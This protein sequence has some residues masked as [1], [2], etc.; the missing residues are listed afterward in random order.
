MY[1]HLFHPAVS[2]WFGEHFTNATQPQLDAWPTIK[3]GQHVLIA[4][5]TGSGKTLAAFLAAIDNLV[6]ES[7]T[8]GLRDETTVLYV[9]PLKALSNDIQKNLQEPLQG[10]SEKLMQLHYP[11]HEI[12]TAVRTGDTPQAE[13]TKMRNKPPHILVTT[14]ES[15][16]ILLTSGSGRSMLSTVKT[17]IVDE[18]HALA[19]NKRG[20]H[21]ALSLERLHEL[22]AS[23][24]V[25]IGLSATQK[26]LTAIA[27]FL[28]GNQSAKQLPLIKPPPC[29][30]VD[31]GHV[32]ERDLAIE[33]PRSPLE[34]VM[35]NEIWQELYDRLEHLIHEH[36][37]TLIFVNTRRLAERAARFLAERLGEE[38]VT[39]HHG[40]LSKEHRLAAEQKL[41]HGQLKALVATASLE[42]GID[43]GDI[44]LVCQIGSPRSIAA[45][46]QRVGRSG[47]RLGAIPKGRLFP[48]SRDDLLECA[49]LLNA[50]R[51][52]ELDQIQV[53][54]GHIDVLAQQ[55]IA[56]VACREWQ[57]DELFELVQRAH[58]YRQ[59]SRDQF[60][61]LI[62]MLVEGF[63]SR[64]GR[65]SR[66]LHYDAVN[67][68]LKARAGTKLTAVTNGGVIPDM[69]DYDV[70]LEPSGQAVGTLNEDFAF[71]SLPGD[72]FQLGNTSYRI[73][74]IEQGKVR[75]E[76]AHGQPPNIPFWIGEGPGRSDVLSH[77]VSQ[78]R[79]GIDQQLKAG[80]N[81]DHWLRGELGLHPA[82]ASQL[83]DYLTA[84]RAAL[85]CIPSQQTIV[86]ERFFDEVGDQHLVVHS[87]YGSR[88]N[89]AWGL[90]LRKR[91]CR[92]FNFE[93]QAAALDDSIVLSLG[94]T[95]S[96]P[97]EDVI[98]FVNSKTIRDVV[99]QAMLAAPMFM[100]H[101]R[102]NATTAL[103]LRRNNAGKKIPAT[104]QRM[105]AEDL[106][107]V[108]FPDQ[109][110][111]Q[112]N[113]TGERE[114]PQH[115]LVDQT[116]EDCLHDVMD[117]DGLI[118][119]LKKI[120]NGSVTIHCVDLNSP[121]PLAHEIL[122][123]RPYAFLD[124]APAE[125]RR[126]LAVV[127]RRFTDPESAAE[128][129][130]LDPNAIAQVRLEAWPAARN[131]EECHD[132]LLLLGFMTDAEA[133][134]S[135]PA[136]CV[137]S[138]YLTALSQSRRAALL[139]HDG[140]R[141]WCCAERLP[142]LQAV[143]PLA[144]WEP[145]IKPAGFNA[146]KSWLEEDALVE[147]LRARLE[148]CGPVK[149]L[150][151]VRTFA[152]QALTMQLALL[153][154]ETEGYAM[155]GYYSTK[156]HNPQPQNPDH[157]EWCERGLLARINRYTIRTLREEIKPVSAAE[158]MQ[159]L[160]LWHGMGEVK[161]QGEEALLTAIRRLE[162]FPIP[163]AAWE[164]DILP[165]RVKSYFPMAL[166]RLCSNGRITWMRH[167]K[168][169]SSPSGETTSKAGLLRNTPVV[170]INRQHAAYWRPFVAGALENIVLSSSAQNVL[171][172]LEQHGASF[173]SDIVHATG[174]LE[175]TAEEALAELSA[176]GRV[177][178]D[179][180]VGLR[181]LIT[182]TNKRPG[183]NRPSRRRPAISATTR[184]DEAG[185]WSIIPHSQSDDDKQRSWLSTD[186]DTLHHIAMSL[187]KRYGVVFRKV[188]E[189]ESR[190]PPWRELLYAYRRMEARGEIRGGRF[191]DGFGGEQFA[192]PDAVGLLRKQRNNPDY[193]AK[194][195]ISA[196]DP[197]NLVGV[198]LPGNRIPAQVGNRIIFTAG[199]AVAVQSGKNIEF[200]EKVDEKQQ[201][202]IQT[203]LV[204]R[205][206]PS[207]LPYTQQ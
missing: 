121:S 182:P 179:N 95:H 201:W 62:G 55:I 90:G 50:V 24:P 205:H 45:F 88:I 106:M 7:L 5:P 123:A 110:A 142:Q 100:T 41:K 57:E 93:L 111:C 104:F 18:I 47:H 160:F 154:L 168:Q 99:I 101:W 29:A 109:L 85:G 195:V 145:A 141:V 91:F 180:F 69:F 17:V 196:S 153:K 86:F 76:D 202:E 10:I 113:I 187:L 188:L 64:R 151:L 63:A 122:T 73:L 38:V 20:T 207:N 105:N 80:E 158:Y 6:R 74:K 177:T 162:G 131:I 149:E 26:P 72:I 75:V 8:G 147:L 94:S 4:A 119:L 19:S 67:K 150:D 13:R 77:Y 191:V 52:E 190:L 124:D 135:N 114:I 9:S 48:L 197:L 140:H 171:A 59:F 87:P 186:E 126:T 194:I 36:K 97:L 146:Q 22:T 39:S 30:I 166:D 56:E 137:Y 172:A 84:T 199:Q 118:A 65:Q 144:I 148:C 164:A 143:Y 184:I 12:R 176:L 46:L 15:L 21:L 58:P 103:A 178:S 115:P 71:E 27:K 28:I 81:I 112:D 139:S 120:E 156:T 117:I 163:A 198:I 25:R 96:F 193:Q 203:V 1:N 170:L 16:F 204:R 60:S 43:I 78:L 185:R 89:R 136:N 61:R 155:Q 33:V 108:V 189:R 79:E 51:C 102:W 34:A 132:A 14:P 200:L 173:F 167:A 66:Y 37:T 98:K 31:S 133:S 183:F 157:K 40:S 161:P 3:R 70:V 116:I 130:S 92:Q 53:P 129:A 181:A 152:H 11:A 2:A 165:A 169:K 175:A 192:L 138:D 49:A 42:L 83:A 54:P 125:E 159:F 107:A 128:L 174:L 23:A 134:G 68:L 32:R 44:D 35:S 82:A 206:T 127:A